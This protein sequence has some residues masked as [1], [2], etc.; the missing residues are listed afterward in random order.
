MKRRKRIVQLLMSCIF[1]LFIYTLTIANLFAP[2][3]DFSDNENRSL[4]KAPELSVQNIFGG[5]FDTEFESWFTDHFINRDTWIEMKASVR[6][7]AGAIENN[8][9]YFG[10]EGRLISAYTSYDPKILDQNIKYINDFS[11]T[12]GLKANIMIVPTAAYGEKKYLPFGSYNIDEKALLN[13]IGTQFKDQNY[14]NIADKLGT[15]GDYYFKTD[16]HWNAAGAKIGYDEICR[17]VLNKDPQEFTYAKVSDDFEGTMY[18]RS[19]AFWTKGDSL[20]RMDPENENPVTVT[21]EDGTVSD[22]MF[23]DKNLKKKD[24]YIYYLDGNHAYEDIHT[25]VDNGRTAVIIKDSY[26][27]I[28][29]PYLAQE[30]SEIKVFDMRYYRQSVSAQVTDPDN[31]DLYFIYSLDTLTSDTNL[32]ALW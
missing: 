17:D 24:Q 1:L 27:H 10:K 31:T 12:T 16:H 8:N 7:N 4:A 14:M 21:Y 25:S 23:I 15:S 22:S 6:K 20:Y 11:D 29:I 26:A 18:S 2:K 9:V 28:L 32:A 30:Y 13:N 19:G 5:N 3:K